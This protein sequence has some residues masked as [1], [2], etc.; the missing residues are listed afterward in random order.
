M[1]GGC[2]SA[3]R[4]ATSSLSPGTDPFELYS[5]RATPRTA[6]NINEIQARTNPSR[7]GDPLP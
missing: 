1:A 7:Y 6:P 2:A 3:N 4:P 5:P